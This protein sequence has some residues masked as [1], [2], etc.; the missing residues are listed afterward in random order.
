MI[1]I[2]IRIPDVIMNK[3]LRKDL[4]ELTEKHMWVTPGEIVYSVY[5]DG[6]FW[7]TKPT[8]TWRIIK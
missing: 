5:H 3:E 4:L 2:K 6:R 1:E 8:R 7:D